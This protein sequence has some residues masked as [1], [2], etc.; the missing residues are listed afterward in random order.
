ML[1]QNCEA[2]NRF[3]KM[4]SILKKGKTAKETFS[5]ITNDFIMPAGL[6]EKQFQNCIAKLRQAGATDDELVLFKQINRE[7]KF[8]V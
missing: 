6:S 5:Q 8:Q 4:R 3:K 2:L 7:N 1:T